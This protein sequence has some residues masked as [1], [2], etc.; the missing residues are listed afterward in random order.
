MTENELVQ[1]MNDCKEIVKMVLG[2]DAK[3]KSNTFH[4]TFN[5]R[6]THTLGR[7]T[8][9][10]NSTHIQLSYKYF[11]HPSTTDDDRYTIMIHEIL[12]A[13]KGCK[14]HDNTFNHY[15]RL[16]EQA[17]GLKGIAGTTT[18][19]NTDYNLSVDRKYTWRAV[20]DDCGATYKRKRKF[21]ADC[22]DGDY[23]ERYRCGKCKG[24]L[25]QE[26]I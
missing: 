23:L 4:V 16:I 2:D 17:T 12:H 10:R 9:R 18:K 1:T 25:V 21:E 19:T 6:F 24:E 14:G 11:N 20:C 15:S 13:V 22:D 3:F 8:N 5:K 26:R 7:C